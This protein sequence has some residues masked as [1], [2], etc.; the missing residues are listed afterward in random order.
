MP[1]EKPVTSA[2]AQQAYDAIASDLAATDDVKISAMFGMPSLKFES[3]AIAGLWGDYM[4][5]K[6]D[7]PSHAKALK[8]SGAQLFDPSGMGRP[9]KAWVQ[10]PHSAVKQ[11]AG[12]ARDA[13][14]VKRAT[15]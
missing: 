3:K 6:L 4:I 14:A 12:L 7:G 5:F 1:M 2:A 8:V 15:G 11:W 13:V 9:M 10:V